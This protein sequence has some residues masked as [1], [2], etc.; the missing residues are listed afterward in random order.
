MLSFAINVQ[1]GESR[2]GTAAFYKLYQSGHNSGSSL[3]SSLGIWLKVKR[4][5]FDSKKTA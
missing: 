1:V 4:K 5:N 2:K 3:K